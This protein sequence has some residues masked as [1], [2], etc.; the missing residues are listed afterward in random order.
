MQYRIL[1]KKQVFYAQNKIMGIWLTIDINYCSYG[2]AVV[3]KA[4]FTNA[5]DAALFIQ[6]R[7]KEKL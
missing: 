5:A 3:G 6:R 2:I 1:S 4:E 7:K